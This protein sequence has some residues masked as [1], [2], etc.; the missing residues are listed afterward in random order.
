LK[1]EDKDVEVNDTVFKTVTETNVDEEH[2]FDDV[3]GKSKSKRVV[4]EETNST[5]EKT[6]DD[7]VGAVVH[8]EEPGADE[9]EDKGEEDTI[10]TDEQK[11]ALLE[12]MRAEVVE[13]LKSDPAFKKSVFGDVVLDADPTP[14]GT[15]EYDYEQDEKLRIAYYD[16][17][18]NPAAHGGDWRRLDAF[19]KNATQ[20]VR[21]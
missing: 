17:L 7:N 21:Y 10:M 12:E 16:M 18:T 19:R 8:D 1:D 5:V 13:S 3:T 14:A 6:D 2:T 9:P 11:K 15:P 4:T 20:K